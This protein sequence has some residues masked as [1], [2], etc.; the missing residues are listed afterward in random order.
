MGFCFLVELV[1]IKGE[2]N[3]ERNGQS[4]GFS[5]T[6]QT[7]LLQTKQNFKYRQECEIWFPSV[8]IRQ[9]NRLAC[10]NFIDDK[11]GKQKKKPLFV[12]G[13]SS[14]NLGEETDF[15]CHPSKRK[16]VFFSPSLSFIIWFQAF[17]CEE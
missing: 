17:S 12:F 8:D 9:Q 2:K 1:C 11:I 15:F 14:T 16:L 7:I 13:I 6:N 5:W 3:G 4:M 10:C